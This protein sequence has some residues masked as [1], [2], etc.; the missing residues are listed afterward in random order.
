MQDVVNPNKASHDPNCLATPSRL[1]SRRYPD[2]PVNRGEERA[3]RE[4]SIKLADASPLEDIL[5]DLNL[6]RLGLNN[7]DETNVALPQLLV[8]L[9]PEARLVGPVL[10]LL[11]Q[12][13]DTAAEAL[14]DLLGQLAHTVAE[15]T[16]LVL[17]R[18]VLLFQTADLGPQI[19]HFAMASGCR[20]AGVVD[21]STEALILGRK[22]LDLVPELRDN[23]V[24][25]AMSLGFCVMEPRPQGF[26]LSSKVLV[27]LFK[28]L[29]LLDKSLPLF[30]ADLVVVAGVTVVMVGSGSLDSD[31]L[32]PPL[33]AGL[34][35]EAS[36]C[37]FGHR[38]SLGVSLTDV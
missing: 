23:N 21:G 32:R 38:L 16:I 5:V 36:R 6:L 18:L 7:S 26:V 10:D 37:H 17:Q 3:K 27:G 2:V 9:L 20:V 1:L 22:V 28:L 12:V 30:A 15:V 25:Q 33:G 34:N 35:V 14:V 31:E 29:V 19:I 11:G 13:G 4:R 8:R 24:A